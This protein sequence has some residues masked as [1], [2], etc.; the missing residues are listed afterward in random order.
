MA[1]ARSWRLDYATYLLDKSQKCVTGGASD[2]K[3]PLRI[4]FKLIL[5]H[6]GSVPDMLFA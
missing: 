4:Q 5:L 1:R 2:H 6:W 3:P